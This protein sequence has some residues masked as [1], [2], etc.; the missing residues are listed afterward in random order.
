MK[1]LKPGSKYLL[2]NFGSD[3]GQTIQFTEKIPGGGYEEGTTNEEMIN[4][5]IDRMYSLQRRAPSA[6]NQ[7]VILLLKQA[8]QTLELRLHNKKEF[9]R[10][11]S[12]EQNT[13]Y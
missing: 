3:D 7:V 13:N 6:E 5:L 4:V 10:K 12:H 1:V 11:K 9:L 8:K 2:H